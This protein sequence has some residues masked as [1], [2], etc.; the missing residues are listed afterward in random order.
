MLVQS[1]KL[2]GILYDWHTGKYPLSVLFLWE[3]RIMEAVKGGT[4]FGFKPG[5]GWWNYLWLKGSNKPK[6]F[7]SAVQRAL[8]YVTKVIG[9]KALQA[10]SRKDATT[11]R[12]DLFVRGLASS[13]V[14]RV[15]TTI[16]AIINFAIQ[17]EGLEFSNPFTSL[18]ADKSI[19]P[20]SRMPFPLNDLYNIQ[21]KCRRPNFVDLAALR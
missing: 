1:W 16:K 10:I 7:Y 4:I 12:D 6:T 19:G 9:N 15:L 14:D 20:K 17:E 3:V 11:V 8:A 13:S 2:I 21:Q 5:W 18:F